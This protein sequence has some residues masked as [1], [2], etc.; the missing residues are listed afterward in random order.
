MFQIIDSGD[1]TFAL[2]VFSFDSIT[3]INSFFFVSEIK[4]SLRESVAASFM[5]LRVGENMFLHGKIKRK[6]SMWIQSL[7]L[8]ALAC[9]SSLLKMFHNQILLIHF[10]QSIYM[11][12]HLSFVEPLSIKTET[13]YLLFKMFLIKWN[14]RNTMWHLLFLVILAD[15]FIQ[16]LWGN[17]RLSVF[18]KDTLVIAH[19]S[20]LTG[21]KP[22][23]FL[24][25]TTPHYYDE[26]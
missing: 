19:G 12:L 21:I 9:L 26:T 7:G 16:S 24:V 3:L 15:S 14:L 17:L 8:Q 23:A 5:T 6:R 4:C 20:F 25:L 22:A 1:D 10:T 2:W 18:L 13:V 11:Y